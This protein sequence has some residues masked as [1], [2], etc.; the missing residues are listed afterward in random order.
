MSG[1]AEFRDGKLTELNTYSP[2]ELVLCL[3]SAIREWV[4]PPHIV[5]IEDSRM[6]S[7]VWHDDAKYGSK[8]KAMKIARNIGM[9]DGLCG[10]VQEICE[11]Y[12]IMLIQLSPKQKGKKLNDKD[13]RLFTG[14]EWHCNQHTRDAAMAGW[15]Y[16]NAVP[17]VQKLP[18][19]PQ[20]QKRVRAV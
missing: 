12:K 14:W 8:Q 17:G 9:V 10:V 15:R 4:E 2:R 3:E 16:R 1:W 7:N 13:F 20:Q 19:Q 6:Q 18:A 11:T 5:V